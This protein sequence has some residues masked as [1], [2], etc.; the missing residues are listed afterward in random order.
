MRRHLSLFVA[1]AVAHMFSG[2]ALADPLALNEWQRVAEIAPP[3][4]G[5]ALAL[6]PPRRTAYLFGGTELSSGLAD[7][8]WRTDLSTS[9]THW[10]RISL[11]AGPGPRAYAHAWFDQAA[12]RLIVL[13]GEGAGATASEV[14]TW[15]RAA[16][17]WTQIVTAHPGPVSIN[18]RYG[19]VFDSRRNRLL[20]FELT[21]PVTSART[22]ALSLDGTPDWS[23]L[24]TSLDPTFGGRCVA[25]YDS[26]GDRVFALGE[27]SK[28]LRMLDLATGA[29][30]VAIPASDSPLNYTTRVN[31]S[32]DG[33]A[34]RLIATVLV[35]RSGTSGLA[36]A[37]LATL[38]F[39][40]T[41][42]YPRLYGPDVLGDLRP[43][44]FDPISRQVLVE[45]A[46][47]GMAPRLFRLLPNT[48]AQ[49]FTWE[50]SM[51]DARPWANTP[52]PN[53]ADTRNRWWYIRDGRTIQRAHLD[54]L[55]R[56]EEVNP[57]GV[58]PTPRNGQG[59][60]WDSVG[61]RLLF[62][63]GIDSTGAY[64]GDLWELALTD[65]P[66]W[67]FIVGSV[68]PFTSSLAIDPVRRY[69]Y[70]TTRLSTLT[71]L[72]RLDLDAVTPGWVLQYSDIPITADYLAYDAAANRLLALDASQGTTIDLDPVPPR[73]SAAVT[74]PG[75]YKVSP[76]MAFDSRRNRMY[77]HNG[78]YHFSNT[79][80][81]FRKET[82]AFGSNGDSVFTDPGVTGEAL[83][84]DYG[85]IATYDPVQDRMLLLNGLEYFYDSSGYPEVDGFYGLWTLQFDPA[86]PTRLDL[87]DA[88]ADAGGDAIRVRFS[89]EGPS[90]EVRVE[91]TVASLDDW[92]E[93]GLATESTPELY[94]FTDV[95]VERGVAYRY[96]GRF[97]VDGQEK[98]TAASDP[99]VLGVVPAAGLA[100]RARDGTI[101]REGP[102]VFACRLPVAGEAV[103]ELVDVRGRVVAR[104]AVRGEAGE[105]FDVTLDPGRAAGA[106]L[107]FARLRQGAARVGVRVVRL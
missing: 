76:A 26:L 28:A 93:V 71:Q 91:R 56:F 43:W 14:W 20:H 85:G 29:W 53:A 94:E 44:A 70:A 38:P 65:P 98:T 39:A 64:V 46:S 13:G 2:A 16:D 69:L 60:V 3:H 103:L 63:G 37:D 52:K 101:G 82:D 78:A 48:P 12:D 22:W 54:E 67:R 6:D 34:N 104:A 72:W 102:I 95:D 50:L 88:V 59:A 41:P 30:S 9:S 100:L 17:S 23:L 55:G 73:A 40:W 97:V 106:G 58:G 36:V 25:A 45:N 75:G 66:Q 11:A 86:T 21:I 4:T 24:P 5:A 33:A 18:Q 68:L 105:P 1:L 81:T 96:R 77:M 10:E 61:S 57:E 51:D 99:V 8:L 7:H 87:V 35:D 74:R 42:P 90:G 31:L 32:W 92:G 27:S 83:L 84:P 107:Y 62:C 49:D 79:G 47:S 15:D 89:G 19:I 80:I